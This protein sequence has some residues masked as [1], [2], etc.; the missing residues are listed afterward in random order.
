MVDRRPQDFP[1][2]E[3][4]GVT[5]NT[6]AI[7]AAIDAWQPGDQVVLS[8][9]TFRTTATVTIPDID[10]VLRGDA[11]VRAKT[12]GGGAPWTDQVMFEVTGTG[13]IFDTD[14][15]RLDQAD[16]IPSGVSVN[17]NGAAGLSLQGL[18][19]RGT[20]LAF[21]RIGDVCPGM[22]VAGIDHLGK[23]YGVFADDPQGLADL[24]VRDSAFTHVGSGSGGD[25]ILVNC[26]THGGSQVEVVGVTAR[27]YIG[28]ATGQGIG[29]AFSRVT[30]GRI[31]GCLAEDCEGDGFH[32]ER[33]SHRWLC[34]DLR[35]IRVGGP[36]PVGGNG[37]GLIAYD[38]DDVVVVLMTVKDAGYHG[39]A[40][41]GQGTTVGTGGQLQ[42][43]G[44]MQRCSVDLTGRDGIHLTA[45]DGVSIDRCFVCDPSNGNPGL[46]AG[47]RVGRQG[48]T[49]IECQNCLGTGN[50]VQLTGATTE[51]AD[52]FVR[53]NASG[54]AIDG[55]GPAAPPV[56]V[57]DDLTVIEDQPIDAHVLANDS[58]VRG[59]E[60]FEI[61]VA[62]THGT[63]VKNLNGTV[64]YDPAL[65][66]TGP[67]SFGYELVDA[68]AEASGTTMLTVV[69]SG[70]PDGE[71][72]QDGT[73]WTDGT[74]WVEAA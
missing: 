13:V 62:P 22:R 39:I 8:G 64:H 23:G 24:L 29:F 74:G 3:P 15:L 27:G 1:D 45:Q 31:V 72:W 44:G 52:R 50:V 37:S 68:A 73:F 67:D 70:D 26:P 36:S 18:V 56:A 48:G 38:C 42:S 55:Q 21:V 25:G 2:G 40:L 47:I 59:T 71:P 35:A 57:D 16:V 69:S 12:L 14:G 63:A 58:F 28:E 5:D 61:T 6:T 7:Q 4:D 34:A 9:G 53:S 32:F 60:N 54:C 30:D 10:L 66:Y 65:G 17:A 20:Q 51:L 19:S 41:S 46:Y 11:V 49:L 43:G 33:A